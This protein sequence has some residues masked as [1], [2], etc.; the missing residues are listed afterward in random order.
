[1]S[2]WMYLECLD[3]DPPITSADEVGQHLY[4]LPDIRRMV[5]ERQTIVRFAKE[6]GALPEGYFAQNA[7]RFLRDHPKCRIRIV[8]EYDVE[9]P[10]IEGDTPA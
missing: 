3:H 9:H 8:D 1:M 10:L 5:A 7:M 2:T 4:D 6:Y